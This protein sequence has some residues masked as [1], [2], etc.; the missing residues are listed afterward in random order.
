MV[1]LDLRAA[2]TPLLNT[3]LSSWSALLVHGYKNVKGRIYCSIIHNV[4]HVVLP[5]SEASR[6]IESRS[7]RQ[8]APSLPLLLLQ[9]CHVR[10]P[11]VHLCCLPRQN[12]YA[13]RIFF[14]FNGQKLQNHVFLNSVQTFLNTCIILAIII[15]VIND[16]I[17]YTPIPRTSPSSPHRLSDTWGKRSARAQ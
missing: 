16:L 17:E 11:P 9:G 10:P 1:A 6:A 8:A 12:V 14:K 3:T 7:G 15:I 5:A 13:F 2:R 4:A